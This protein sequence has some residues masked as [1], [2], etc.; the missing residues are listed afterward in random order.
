MLSLSVPALPVSPHHIPKIG[1]WQFPHVSICNPTWT[2]KNSIPIQESNAKFL[3]LSSSCTGSDPVCSHGSESKA[4]VGFGVVFP[5][6]NWSGSLCNVASVFTAELSAVVLALQVI[7]TFSPSKFIIF[8]NSWSG[9]L[10]LESFNSLT[11][12]PFV[13]S[14]MEWLNV[15]EHQGHQVGFCSVPVHVGVSGNE[16]SD[17]PANVTAGWGAP[18]SPLPRPYSSYLSSDKSLPTNPW[19][20]HVQR[21]WTIL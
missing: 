4:G 8:S 9:I 12:H 21:C 17:R 16:K 18:P 1:F 6:F 20:S 15:L 11:N 2:N 7:L 10:A 14:I 5:L 19:M 3:E 13:L